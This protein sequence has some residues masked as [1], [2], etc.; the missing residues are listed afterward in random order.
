[1]WASQQ[2]PEFAPLLAAF[3]AGLN[4]WATEHPDLLSAPAKAALPLTVA[5]VLANNQRVIHFD[6]IASRARVESIVK[7]GT[8]GDAHGS[9]GWAIAPARSVSGNAMLMSN[10]HVNWSDRQTYFEVQLVAP[11]V[12][13]S[14]AVWVGFPTLRQCFNDRLGWT[15][16]TNTF[17]GNREAGN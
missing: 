13:M 3:V 10:S 1:L 15:Q 11:G 2:S 6:W 7:L 9:N 17:D 5:D 12:N 4:G 16:T 14:G 8:T